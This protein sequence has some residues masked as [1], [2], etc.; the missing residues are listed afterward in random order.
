MS[1]KKTTKLLFAVV[2]IL[3]A[4]T[5]VSF[6]ADAPENRTVLTIGST[7]LSETDVLRLLTGDGEGNEMMVMLML[8]QSTLPERMEMVG[9]MV[10]FFVLAEAAKD[11]KVEESADVAFQIK[12]QTAQILVQ[13]YF[14]KISEKWDFS[15]EAALKHYDT[16]SE[17]FALAEAVQA[18]HILTE[19]ESDALMA[20]MEAM[21][22]DDFAAVAQ[23]YS[24]DPNTAQNGG[25]LGWVVKGQ[26]P[27]PLEDAI[28]K[29]RSGQVVGP[30]ASEAGWHVVKIGEHRA[31]KKMTFEEASGAIYQ[32]MQ[33]EYLE[34]DIAKLKEKYKISVNEE[35]LSTLGGLPAP[36]PAQ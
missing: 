17:T 32:S 9:Q 23:K 11:E 27:Q 6:A 14:D 19:T 34:R 33:N 24:R 20:A 22:A 12:L 26:L 31:A 1:M 30:I 28:M 21:A 4:A 7:S 15:R 25:D 29:G 36:A 35:A 2:L 5:S 10:D 13:S 16:H 3:I 18:A 8:S